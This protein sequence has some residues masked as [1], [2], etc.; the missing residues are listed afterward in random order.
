MMAV[1]LTGVSLGIDGRIA[2]IERVEL[3]KKL[4]VVDERWNH[5]GRRHQ[6][7]LLPFPCRGLRPE[8]LKILRV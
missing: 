6:G 7:S 4:S 1:N 5:V 8:S 3:G 2:D